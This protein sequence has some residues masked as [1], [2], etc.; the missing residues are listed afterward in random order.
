[1]ST[2]FRGLL[3]LVCSTGDLDAGEGYSLGIPKYHTDFYAPSPMARYEGAFFAICLLLLYNIH[4]FLPMLTSC[5]SSVRLM[6]GCTKLRHCY[7]IL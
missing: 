2:V 5:Y 1:M 3:W 6:V 4:P 7:S